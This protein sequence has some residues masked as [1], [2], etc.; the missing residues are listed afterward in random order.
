MSGSPFSQHW[1]RVADLTPGLRPHAD[2]HRHVYRG[3]TWYVVQD[4]ASGEFHYFTPEAHRVIGLMDGRTS[5]D[6]IWRAACDMLGDEMPSQDEIIELVSKLHRANLLQ[7]NLPPDAR[8]L[9]ERAEQGERRKFLQQLKSPLGIRIPLLDPEKFLTA[10]AWL[11]DPLLS[12]FGA[13]VWLVVC[14]TGGVLALLHWDTLTGNVTDQVLSVENLIA[15]SLVYPVVKVIHELGH[16]YAVKRWGGEVHEMGAMLLVFFPVPYVD[17]SAASAFNNKYARAL[18]GAAGI[19]VEVFIA[20]VA[21]IVWAMVE[22]GAVRSLAFNVMLIAGVSTV[23]F[24]GNPLLRFD[25]YYVLCDLLEIPNLGTRGNRHVGYLIKRFL[26]GVKDARSPAFSDSEACWLS[27]YAVAAFVYRMFILYVIVLFVASQYFAVGVAL[28]IWAAAGG[29][30]FP[31]YQTI[32]K[33]VKDPQIKRKPYRTA[34]VYVLAV[35][36][37]VGLFGFLPAPLTTTVEGVVWPAEDTRVRAA[38]NGF[39]HSL[40]VRPGYSVRPGDVLLRTVDPDLEGQVAVLKAQIAEA[41]ARRQSSIRNVAERIVIDDEKR[42]LEQELARAEERAKELSIRSPATG[43]LVMPSASSML[44]RHVQRGEMLAYVVEPRGLTVQAAVA[45]DEIDLIRSSTETIEVLFQSKLSQT[46]PARIVKQVPGASMALPSQVLTTAGGG[47]I[48]PNPRTPTQVESDIEGIEAFEPYFQF[49]LAVD[50][51]DK[52]F[53]EERV[54]VR[55]THPHEPLAFR[56]YRAARRL[57]L[58]QLDV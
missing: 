53:I 37:P 25:A 40:V 45:Q 38:Q 58:R 3:R 39:I 29:I 42:H 26:I 8:E 23:L 11:A 43:F 16:G 30:L 31:L 1:Y 2:L 22:P 10:T 14:T 13:F 6:T 20:G 18:V 47:R 46:F 12:W 27:S 17:A 4:H 55:F 44:G 32:S 48:A 9:T 19:L 56:W 33:S 41:E 21:M 36:I 34:I 50:G 49:E 35:A 51:V 57:L 5:L 54:H 15:L 24:N 7:T 52:P 28:A